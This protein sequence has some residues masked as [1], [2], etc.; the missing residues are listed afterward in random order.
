MRLSVVYILPDFETAC[1]DER[2]GVVEGQWVAF[3][4]YATVGKTVYS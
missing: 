4:F 1:I 2:N 3:E